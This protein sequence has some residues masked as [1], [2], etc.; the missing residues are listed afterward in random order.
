MF[1]RIT[2]ELHCLEIS[3]KEVP[4]DTRASWCFNIEVDQ[5]IDVLWEIGFLQAEV[6]GNE[7]LT[8]QWRSKY[9]GSHQIKRLNLQRIKNFRIHPLFYTFLGFE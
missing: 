2:L 8:S 4:V 9:L 3:M 5:L 7:S 1:D 6:I